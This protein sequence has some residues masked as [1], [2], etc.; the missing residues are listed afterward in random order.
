MIPLIQAILN[1]I[2]A[3][4]LLAIPA[5][6]LTAMFAVLRYANFSI[7]ALATI[8]AFAAWYANTVFGWSEIPALIAAF[9]VA[10]LVGMLVEQLA[11]KRLRP[12]GALTVA[13][14]S[15]A[16]SVL[17]E[18]VV[19]FIF[20]NDLRAFD[21]PLVRDWF[22]WGLRVGPQQLQNVIIAVVI[23]ALVFGFLSLTRYGKAMRAVAD[24][25]D[26]ARIYRMDPQ[27]IA[28]AT[29]ALGTGLAGV[30]GMLLGL[31]S[32]IEP[33]TGSRLLLPIFAAA[34]LGGLGSIPGALLGALI[35][36]VGEEISLLFMPATYRSAIGFV[37]IL[38]VLSMRPQ[39]I[40]GERR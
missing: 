11:L 33:M 5:M 8:G 25:P 35:I 20:G 10:A 26:L 16:A 37:V 13:I 38:L 31:D 7:G 40:L 28:M 24:N 36:G 23:M 6:G 2:M 4:S 22:F 15:I 9:V 12:A 17:L 29:V 3:G 32:A 19:R 21:T 30:G 27:K 14:A 18:N 1:G 39:G 34:V